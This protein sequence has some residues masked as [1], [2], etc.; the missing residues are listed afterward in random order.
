M[1][2]PSAEHELDLRDAAGEQRVGHLVDQQGAGRE[3]REFGIERGLP[4]VGRAAAI[5][6]HLRGDRTAV[7]A[8]QRD[9]GAA[10]AGEIRDQRGARTPR[11]RR[12][13]SSAVPFAPFQLRNSRS[14]KTSNAA[15]APS[16][17]RV[18]RDVDRAERAEAIPVLP[19]LLRRR[20]G[21]LAVGRA[22]QERPRALGEFQHRPAAR[23]SAAISGRKRRRVAVEQLELDHVRQARARRR[24][25]ARKAGTHGVVDDR[26]SITGFDTNA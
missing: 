26:G 25:H 14:R 5:E 2:L 18:V 6:Q 3:L 16:A 13:H 15:R 8:Q 24:S 11:P 10:R 9:R 23:R 22:C 1:K 12:A 7:E 19:Q 20:A 21:A 4:G 17:S